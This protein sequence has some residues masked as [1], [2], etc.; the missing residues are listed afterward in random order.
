M[1]PRIHAHQRRWEQKTMRKA[2]ETASLKSTGEAEL[3]Y[4]QLVECAPDAYIVS[5][6]T[7]ALIL[8]VNQAACASLGY[9]RSELLRLSVPD[10]SPELD[11]SAV[12]RIWDDVRKGE[13]IS[14]ETT[15]R[16][17]DGTTFPV[18]IRVGVT[19]S[20]PGRR[21]L[22]LARDISE[23]SGQKLSYGLAKSGIATWLSTR[24]MH[25]LW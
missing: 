7:T 23:R 22:G 9:A 16:R 19:G 17:K 8:D 2:N 12:R 5:D 1:P 4:R 14:F 24:Q 6:P 15:R 20:G 21:M 11:H 3:R 13:P 18:E 25:F 10:I